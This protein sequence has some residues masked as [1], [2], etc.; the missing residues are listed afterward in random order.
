M[1]SSFLCHP[2][3]VIINVPSTMRDRLT[4]AASAL[5][6]AALRAVAAHARPNPI[7][8]AEGGGGA[9]RKWRRTGET[10]GRCAFTCNC[11]HCSN[12]YKSRW[13]AGSRWVS[14]LWAG[15]GA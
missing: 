1:S 9:L 6:V 8:A 10:M 4:L 13:L 5:P 12:A 2:L 11:P 7:L 14:W 3:I 15:A